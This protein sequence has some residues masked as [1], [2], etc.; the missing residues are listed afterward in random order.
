M[1]MYVYY[2]YCIYMHVNILCKMYIVHVQ[3]CVQCTLYM[4]VYVYIHTC[5]LHVLLV[6]YNETFPE[7]E[8]YTGNNIR[9][10]CIIILLQA[11]WTEERRPVALC[12]WR[13]IYIIHVHVYVQHTCIYMYRP[14]ALGRLCSNFCLFFYFF[15]LT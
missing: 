15:M 9:F 6:L 5:P 13:G 4:Y 11:W 12:E 7:L 10:A 14:W 3:I 2:M 1:Y 8:Q